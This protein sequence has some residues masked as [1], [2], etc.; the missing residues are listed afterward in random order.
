MTF[1][2]CSPYFWRENTVRI[3]K[4]A[5][6]HCSLYSENLD[7]G[8]SFFSRRECLLR[9][10]PLFPQIRRNR[11]CHHF[12]FFFRA[13][14]FCSVIPT[15]HGIH[16]CILFEI[17]LSHMSLKTNCCNYSTKWVIFVS[18]RVHSPPSSPQ[19]LWYVTPATTHPK[20]AAKINWLPPPEEEKKCVWC[21][22][23]K[24]LSSFATLCCSLV[25]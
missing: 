13:R 1:W 14:P 6:G 23:P 20:K 7:E 17:P 21:G 3:P 25:L 12:P 11:N 18:G 15:R 5:F 22:R 16:F 24:V 8:I 9:P 4:V 19:S 10:T 2:H